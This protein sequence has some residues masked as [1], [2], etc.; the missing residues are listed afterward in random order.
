MSELKL[1]FPANVIAGK[2]KI[3]TRDI[4]A[5]KADLFPDGIRDADGA[6]LLFALNGAC[7]DT[8][9]EW[10]GFFVESLT[11][12]IVDRCHPR[13]TLDDANAF[14]IERML[15]AD[16]VIATGLE[17]ELLNAILKHSPHVPDSLKVF[18]LSQIR[19]A[20]HSGSG[21]YARLRRSAD[22]GVSETDMAFA[23]LVIDAGGG[24]GVAS[25]AQHRV[26]LSIDAIAHPGLNVNGWVRFLFMVRPQPA[27]RQER[28]R[29]SR[30]AA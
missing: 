22:K 4:A 23:R 13:G 20:I 5:L 27:A 14:W 9:P 21:A 2:G 7:R 6:V 8:C 19:H 15:A 25:A 10:S 11:T 3:T 16:G 28:K 26:L 29:M 17:F 18:A 1:P 12:F 24:E 30:V